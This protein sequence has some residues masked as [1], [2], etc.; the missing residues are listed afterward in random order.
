MVIAF[1]RRS[2]RGYARQPR[3]GETDTVPACAE[4]DHA[5]PTRAV[6][7]LSGVPFVASSTGNVLIEST[8][9]RNFVTSQP[10]LTN[11]VRPGAR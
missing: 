4:C 6:C 8:G 3:R 2:D 10:A 7:L 9:S 5:A 11:P 1:S